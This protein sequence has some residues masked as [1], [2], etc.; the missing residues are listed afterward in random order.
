M[1]FAVVMTLLLVAFSA[2]ALAEKSVEKAALDLI[3]A[4]DDDCGWIFDS[5]EKHSDCCESFQLG[6]Q[7]GALQKRSSGEKASVETKKDENARLLDAMI[8]SSICKTNL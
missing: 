5:C 4:R 8:L 3:I 7:Q 6:L 1:K 2:V